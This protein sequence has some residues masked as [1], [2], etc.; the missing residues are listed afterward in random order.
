M[1][2]GFLNTGKA[3]IFRGK[4]QRSYRT[5]CARWLVFSTLILVPFWFPEIAAGLA[6]RS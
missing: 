2:A 1:D 5:S 6:T 3:W 4:N